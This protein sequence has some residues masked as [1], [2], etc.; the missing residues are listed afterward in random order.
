MCHSP[1]PDAHRSGVAGRHAGFTLLELLVVLVIAGTLMA[2]AYPRYQHAMAETRLSDGQAALMR[3]ATRLER[4]HARSH[5]YQGCLDT[6]RLSAA[7][8]FRITARLDANAYQ[9]TATHDDTAVFSACR[10][11]RLDARGRQQPVEC[12]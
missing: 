8:H 9:L 2:V 6:P 4:C 3:L 1:L 10:V 5:S 12:W 11:L 7:G